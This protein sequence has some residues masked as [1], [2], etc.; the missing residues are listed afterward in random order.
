MYGYKSAKKVVIN[1]RGEADLGRLM[2]AADALAGSMKPPFSL[3]IFL[4]QHTDGC[5]L[6][7]KE[8]VQ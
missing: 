5:I 4:T 7:V 6:C 3:K 2:A 8:G 1:L